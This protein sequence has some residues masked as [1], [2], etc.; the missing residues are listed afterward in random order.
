MAKYFTKLDIEVFRGII[1]LSLTDLGDVNII[2]GD[3]NSGKTSILEAIQIISEPTMGNFLDVAEI[4]RNPSGAGVKDYVET[5]LSIMQKHIDDN[6]RET[7]YL[8]IAACEKNKPDE[9][10]IQVVAKRVSFL[11]NAKVKSPPALEFEL[12]AN[13][14]S[15]TYTIEQNDISPSK[16]IAPFNPDEIVRNFQRVLIKAVSTLHPSEDDVQNVNVGAVYAVDH[17]IGS[18]YHKILNSKS[19]TE[20]AIRLLDIF[21]ENIVT[22]RY[23]NKNGVPVPIVDTDTREAVPLSEYGDGLKKTFAM[24]EAILEA[25]NGI[26]LIDE[27]ESAIHPSAMNSVFSFIL[28]VCKELNVQ[29]FMTTHSIEAID[30]LLGCDEA[31]L[32]TI[33]VI[34]LKK[35]NGKIYSRII[36]GQEAEQLRQNNDAELR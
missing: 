9:R 13:G 26:L 21:K 22:M 19:Q 25:E 4:R 1:G 5:A 10:Y 36:N 27:Y 32:D 30:K 34:T 29:T 23:L 7:Y 14:E 3:N 6:N 35:K 2:V 28:R 15:H 24:M 11:E 8:H 33:R 16:R 17:I 31:E 20:K 18:D 12:N